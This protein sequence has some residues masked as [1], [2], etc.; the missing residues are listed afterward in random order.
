MESLSETVRETE[1][2]WRQ[3]Q[4]AESAVE[5]LPLLQQSSRRQ[6]T[7][8]KSASTKSDAC[9]PSSSDEVE[10]GECGALHCK[11]AMYK[12][13]II[14]WIQCDSCDKYF[15]AY[16]LGLKRTPENDYFCPECK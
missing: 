15:H 12:G 4:V 5:G 9:L 16:C 13:S 6:R 2:T 3:K 11:I 1:S 7:Q 8:V 14:K 10:D